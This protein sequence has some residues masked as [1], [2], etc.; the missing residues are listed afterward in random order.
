MATSDR[1]HRVF[2]GLAFLVVGVVFLLENFT[3]WEIP[4]GGW[5][6]VILIAVG[7]WNIVRNR[8]WFGGL[9]VA[10]LGVFFLPGYTGCVGVHHRGHLAVLA[11]GSDPGRGKN[12]LQAETK[13][14]P[15]GYQGIP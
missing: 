12:A 9:V 5:W 14:T 13:K 2:V 1:G 3:D 15:T 10:A 4:W 11:G 6:P 7:I 8:S